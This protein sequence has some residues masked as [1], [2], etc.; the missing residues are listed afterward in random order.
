MRTQTRLCHIGESHRRF[1]GAETAR[2]ANRL[3]PITPGAWTKGNLSKNSWKIQCFFLFKC[4]N[5]KIGFS[6]TW[7]E[8]PKPLRQGIE[9]LGLPGILQNK[10][11]NKDGIG[12]RKLVL[13]EIMGPY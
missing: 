6:R 11:E 12:C 9:P 4:K 7:V 3:V 8:I 5:R 10:S 1:L 2:V 13:T